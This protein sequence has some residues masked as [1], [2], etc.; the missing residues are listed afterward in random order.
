MPTID[1]SDNEEYKAINIV[2]ADGSKGALPIL[3]VGGATP[4]PITD[5]ILERLDDLEQDANWIK[6]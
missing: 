2:L 6:T 4:Q 1:V 3:D 5:E